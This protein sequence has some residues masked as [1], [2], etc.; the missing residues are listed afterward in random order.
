MR[1]NLLKTSKWISLQRFN[2]DL[3]VGQYRILYDIAPFGQG[4]ALFVH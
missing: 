4:I 3:L 1:K 2:K